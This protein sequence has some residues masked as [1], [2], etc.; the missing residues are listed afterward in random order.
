MTA[1]TCVCGRPV[2]DNARLCA[3]RKDRNG[4][5]VSCTGRLE[6]DLGDL[7]ALADELQTTRLRQSRTGGQA[8]GVLSRSYERPLPWDERAAVTADLLRSTVVA[9][10]RIVLD[11]RGGRCPQNTVKDMATFLMSQLE[12]IRHADQT[13]EMPDEIRHVA[14]EA[15]RV[16]DIAPD[17]LYIGPCDPDGRWGELPC[18]TDLYARQGATETA[19]P[20]CELV[21]NVEN[22][23]QVMLEAAQDRLV[24]AADLSKFLSAYGEPL[25]ADRIRKWV[26]REQ[27]VPHGRDSAGRPTYRVSEAT[28]LLA[29]MNERRKAS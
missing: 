1:P 9:W 15:R 3:N 6:R 18:P 5:D 20:T 16:V 25:T 24:T 19:C 12:W 7:G 4:V 29:S 21:W 22:R 28:D 23:R 10:V 26:E 14:T 11:E 13:V 8:T 17:R 27:L 2:A